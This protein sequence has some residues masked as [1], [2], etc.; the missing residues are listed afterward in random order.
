MF[1]WIMVAITAAFV[2]AYVATGFR[3]LFIVDRQ[4]RRW[5]GKTGLWEG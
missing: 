5:L 3:A 1:D 2:L 4:I